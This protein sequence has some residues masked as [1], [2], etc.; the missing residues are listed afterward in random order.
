MRA[1]STF[2]LLI[3]GTVLVAC[4]EKNDLDETNAYHQSEKTRSINVNFTSKSAENSKL[5]FDDFSVLAYV[6][7]T[8]VNSKEGQVSNSSEWNIEL[9]LDEMVTLFS[10]AN[11]GQV[12]L[13]DS[14]TTVQ[15]WLDDLAQ[16][17]VFVSNLSEMPSDKSVDTVHFELNRMVG[18]MTF[19]PTED[20]SAINAIT[21]FD[22]IEVSFINTNVAYLPKDNVSVQDTVSIRTTMAEGFKAQVYSFP[23]YGGNAGTVEVT[24]FKNNL[25]VN[26][27]VRALDVAINV[28]A[29]KRSTVLMP[30]LDENYLQNPFS[31][32]G[33]VKPIEGHEPVQ[34]IE[35]QF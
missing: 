1:I 8:L 31:K 4:S 32:R 11:A 23:T 18:Q 24:Y 35:V 19:E 27:T 13:T 25:E 3:V 10:C 22:A 15:I 29:S 30:I 7:D 6:S 28:E 20:L 9:P 16:N 5:N 12:Q 33:V 21:A 17:E 34:L 26:K 14:L 2:I